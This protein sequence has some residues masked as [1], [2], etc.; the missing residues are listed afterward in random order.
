VTA[1]FKV[2]ENGQVLTAGEVMGFMMRQMVCVF[3]DATERDADITDPQHGQF[4]FMRD[5]NEIVFYNG[6]SWGSL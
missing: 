1:G 3:E 5:T 4:A 6:T 2:F